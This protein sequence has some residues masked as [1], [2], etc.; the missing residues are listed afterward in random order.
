MALRRSEEVA[1]VVQILLVLRRRA[2][3]GVRTLFD[4]LIAFYANRPDTV[5]VDALLEAP[6]AA[7]PSV[8]PAR[9]DSGIRFQTRVDVALGDGGAIAAT[10]PCFV[11]RAETPLGEFA[12]L[13]ANLDVARWIRVPGRIGP[14]LIEQLHQAE[15]RPVRGRDLAALRE[16]DQDGWTNDVWNV[17]HHVATINTLALGTASSLFIEAHGEPARSKGKRRKPDRTLEPPDGRWFQ[18]R[19]NVWRIRELRVE[20]LDDIETQ[21]AALVGP[22]PRGVTV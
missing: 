12:W 14:K 21:V 7:G 9:R 18:I 13:I 5:G 2:P 16:R 4:P 15:G 6:G 19:P 3:E 22:P 10:K 1:Y 17:N 20:T 11:V 8:Q